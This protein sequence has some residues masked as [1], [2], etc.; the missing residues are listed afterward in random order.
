MAEVLQ[1]AAPHSGA[2]RAEWQLG[3]K[4]QKLLAERW[5]LT[6]EATLGQILAS[7]NTQVQQ[8]YG[9]GLTFTPFNQTRVLVITEASTAA[10]APKN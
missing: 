7:L 4:G 3:E 6:A 10:I 5:S 1:Q 8:E 9:F 2:W